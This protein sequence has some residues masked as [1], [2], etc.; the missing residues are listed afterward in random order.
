MS[1]EEGEQQRKVLR[2]PASPE[3]EKLP[4][5]PSAKKAREELSD[6]DQVIWVLLFC[7]N[8]QMGMLLFE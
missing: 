5:A 8:V 2:R 7:E 6:G 1:E 4:E 3:P